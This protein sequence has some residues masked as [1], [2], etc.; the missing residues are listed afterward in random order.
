MSALL[1][2]P[3]YLRKH[4]GLQFEAVWSQHRRKVL[5]AAAVLAVFL[6]W[7]GM[8]YTARLFVNFKEDAAELGF[9]AASASTLMLAVVFVR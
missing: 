6:L 4:I 8:W 1:R 9:L 5:A 2:S 3:G 7:R